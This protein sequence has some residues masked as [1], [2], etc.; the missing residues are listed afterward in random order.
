ML[1][2]TAAARAVFPLFSRGNCMPDPETSTSG[3]GANRNAGTRNAFDAMGN[4]SGASARPGL[5]AGAA[6][7]A[8]IAAALCAAVAYYR[9]RTASVRAWRNFAQTIGGEFEAKSAYSPR[10]VSGSMGDR[11]VF[12]E[13]ST[14]HEDDAPY[15]HTRVSTPVFNPGQHT[16]GLR[17]KSMLEE[18]QTRGSDA[19]LVTG[20][21]D[22]DGRFMMAAGDAEA[23]KSVLTPEVR[24]GLVKY[25]DVEIY[26]A[27]EVLEWRRAG[28][29]R[30]AEALKHLTQILVTLAEGIDRLPARGITLSQK[31]SE[32]D[33]LRKGV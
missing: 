24:K 2:I 20:D 21:R 33:L 9:F 12:V 7:G 18:A 29:V 28:E 8:G 23:L 4:P 1:L 32:Q 27:G 3:T 25:G 10:F 15:Y 6:V 30:D 19:L 26:L 31:L 13:T 22:F 5:P 17:R 14:S 11:A 16:F